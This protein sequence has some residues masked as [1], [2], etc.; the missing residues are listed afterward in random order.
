MSVLSTLLRVH[1]IYRGF[2]PQETVAEEAATAALEQR[3]TSGDWRLTEEEER[4]VTSRVYGV[5][6]SLTE[7]RFMLATAVSR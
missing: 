3:R 4:A 1:I 7:L 5:A 2:R 6:T